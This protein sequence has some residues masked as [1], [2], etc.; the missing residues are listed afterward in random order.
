VLVVLTQAETASPVRR[1]DVEIRPPTDH[2]PLN[3]AYALPAVAAGSE[4]GFAYFNY[5]NVKVRLRHV[6]G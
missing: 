5:F 4:I 6:S 2:E 1:V 3:S